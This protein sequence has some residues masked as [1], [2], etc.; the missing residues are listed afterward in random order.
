MLALLVAFTLTCT[1]PSTGQ[2]VWTD[3]SAGA[4]SVMVDCSGGQAIHQLRTARLYW[5]PIQ[6][7]G[8]RLLLEDSVAG[9]EGLPHDFT[10]DPG[11]GGHAY[12]T[13]TNTKGESCASNQVYVPGSLVTAVETPDETL[14]AIA[15]VSVFDVQGRRVLALTGLAWP[16]R[17]L[18]A[19]VRQAV[20]DRR[21]PSGIY[22]VRGATRGGD[23]VVR[24]M[25]ILR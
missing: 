18:Q 8:W 17:T 23:P 3:T 14:G 6:G 10:F 25:A 4:D 16:V 13:A 1:L 2:R 24:R 11:Q 5:N 9:Q 15:R 21:L 22:F 20:M 7:G 12:A 19:K